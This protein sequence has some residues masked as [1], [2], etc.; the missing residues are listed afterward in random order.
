MQLLCYFGILLNLSLTD[1][2]E[3][4]TVKYYFHNMPIVYE[5]TLAELCYSEYLFYL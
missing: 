2:Q 1:L 4:S 3:L 5:K